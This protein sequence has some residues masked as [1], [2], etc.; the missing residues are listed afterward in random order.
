MPLPP[1]LARRLAEVGCDPA[2]PG[3]PAAAWLALHERFG[4]RATLLD[5][6]ALEAAAR[7]IDPQELTPGERARL[8]QAVA[9]AHSPAIEV[10]GD[11]SRSR[12]PVEIVEPDPAWPDRFE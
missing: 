7:G 12:D 9:L 2:A 6:Y 11:R 8:G 1:D 4:P 10:L 5:R 3:D